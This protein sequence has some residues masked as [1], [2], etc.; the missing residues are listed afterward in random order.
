MRH[1]NI[2][3]VWYESIICCGIYM[4]QYKNTIAVYIVLVWFVYD[5]ILY[6]LGGYLV[7]ATSLWGLLSQQT[8]E[9]LNTS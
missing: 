3:C 5:T 2:T 7:V 8:K 1:E 9:Q 6:L 4:G